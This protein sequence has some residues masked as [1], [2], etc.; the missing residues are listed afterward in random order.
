MLVFRIAEAPNLFGVAEQ[1]VQAAMAKRWAVI[2]KRAGY[3]GLCCDILRDYAGHVGRR[4]A[5]KA[6]KDSRS[7]TKEE[8]ARVE[9]ELG[10]EQADP[11]GARERRVREVFGEKADAFDIDDGWGS[12]LQL[13]MQLVREGLR[14]APLGE[15]FQKAAPRERPAPSARC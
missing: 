11:G 12:V 6:H 15:P 8:L 7:L 1:G 14:G 3:C 5:C 2:R 9:E 13:P 10:A 4:P